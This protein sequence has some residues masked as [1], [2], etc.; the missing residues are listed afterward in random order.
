MDSD[1]K[2]KAIEDV[3]DYAKEK[4]RENYGFNAEDIINKYGEEEGALRLINKETMPKYEKAKDAGIPL[5]DFYNAWVA[6]KNAEG[7][8]NAKGETISGTKKKAK[9]KAINSAVDDDLTT[10]QKKTLYKLFNVD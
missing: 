10:Y 3:Y 5:V 1:K 2:E 6:Q 9:I 4:A 7:K 8:K